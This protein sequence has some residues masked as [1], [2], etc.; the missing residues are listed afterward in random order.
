ML[1]TVSV[2]VIATVASFVAALRAMRIDP[3][4]IAAH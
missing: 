1:V 3:R 2:V 4:A